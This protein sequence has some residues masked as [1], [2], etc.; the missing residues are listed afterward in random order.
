LKDELKAIEATSSTKGGVT[1][2]NHADFH[3]VIFQAKSGADTARAL[4]AMAKD[5]G[6]KCIIMSGIA[7]SLGTSKTVG[8]TTTFEGPDLGDVVVATSLAPFDLRNKVRET[9]KN[10]SVPFKQRT[11]DTL[12]TDPQLFRLAHEVAQDNSSD[13]QAVYEGLTVTGTGIKDNLAERRGSWPNAQE[14]WQS[15][16]KV[17]FS[18]WYA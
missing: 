6:V 12:P 15:R 18:V 8:G 3:A 2:V 13:F 10:V 4:E 14:E 17:T 7:G 16:K 5:H 11:W 1:T 9:V